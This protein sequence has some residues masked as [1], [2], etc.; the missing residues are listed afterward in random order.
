[1]SDLTFGT[2]DRST[3]T[4]RHDRPARTARWRTLGL[5]GVVAL[6]LVASACMSAE[7]RTFLDR[8]NSLRASAGA[9]ALAEN[10]TLTHKAE[11]WA[12][13]MAATGQLA[14][15]SLAEG[16][17]GLQWRAL[18]ENVAVSD[19]NGDT[20]LALHNAMAGSG[21]H[22]Q[23]MVSREYT[24]MGVGVATGRDGRVWVA[25]VFARL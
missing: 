25:E 10:D 1:M 19:P 8:T 14:H 23:N 15:S 11:Q 2:D 20:L 22:R 9:P 5:V 3:G 16:L 21:A 6:A 12:A 17:D 7:G 24:H 4:G 13:H 18:A